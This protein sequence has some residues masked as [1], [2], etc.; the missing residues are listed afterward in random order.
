MDRTQPAL[1]AHNLSKFLGTI[2]KSNTSSIYPH[3][4]FDGLLFKC[5]A[6]FVRVL[7][8][9]LKNPIPATQEYLGLH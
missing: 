8:F 4:V 1:S 6:P 7:E 2:T 9:L 3:I 5:M